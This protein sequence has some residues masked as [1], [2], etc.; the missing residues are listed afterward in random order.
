M[1]H[2]VE[3]SSDTIDAFLLSCRI[4]GCT[5]LTIRTYEEV[6]QRLSAALGRDVTG[7]TRLNIQGHLASL[8]EIGLKQITV[9]K[10]YRA[11]RGYLSW[12]V[13][14]GLITS[15]P[16]QGFS[17]RKPHTFPRVPLDEDIQKALSRCPDSMDGRRT[18]SLLLLFAD[19]GLRVSEAVRLHIE[20]VNLG[21]RSATVRIGKG[22]KARVVFFGAT[23]AK[24]IRDYL[25]RREMAHPEDFLFTSQ[26]GRPVTRFQVAHALTNLS[27]RAGLQRRLSPHKLRHFF[28]TA[29]LRAGGDMESLRQ[30]LGH[31]DLTM[32]LQYCHML[33]LDISRNYRRASPVDHVL[34]TR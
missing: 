8:Y 25:A 21:L 19:S 27:R 7:L 29:F 32:T 26:D 6:L 1:A 4:K 12:L 11:I 20:D 10:H 13:E 16:L 24:A 33:E 9:H 28:A 2:A 14:A 22:Q 18:R 17:M 15:H 31:S 34:E 3:T 5:N 30:L 23:T